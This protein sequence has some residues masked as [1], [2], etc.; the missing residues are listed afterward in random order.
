MPRLIHQLPKAR[1][2]SPSGRARVRINGK[3][4]WLGPYGS[5]EAKEKYNKLI[6]TYLANDRKIPEVASTEVP[7]IKRETT[8]ARPISIQKTVTTLPIKV[9]TITTL[10]ARFTEWADSNYRHPDGTKTRQSENFKHVTKPLREMFGT[11]PVADFDSPRL[12][13]LRES[14]IDKKLAR[15]TIN[16]M[17]SRVRWIFKWG[18]ARGLV[19]NEV[20]S[21]LQA[22]APLQPHR[23][24]RE[25]SGTR[26]SVPWEVVEKTLEYLP[27]LIRSFVLVAFHSGARVGELTKLTTRMIDMTTNPWVVNLIQHKTAHKGKSRCLYFGPN[28]QRA[29]QPFLLANRPDAPIFSPLRVDGR[30]KKRRGKRLPGLVYARS[31]LAQ[32]LRR[33]IKRAGVEHWSLAQLRHSAALRITNKYDLETTRQILGHVTV[34]MTRHYAQ[35]ADRAGKEAVKMIG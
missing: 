21:R 12:I 25:T 1:L 8:E 7:D 10:I 15:R 30:Q 16:Q 20:L 33:A 17:V 35:E 29:L 24:G 13:A 27:P 28:A 32:V 31:S 14:W 4:H 22:L 23:G 26:G 5:P 3:D 19:S 6:A 34:E 2:H 18:I 11:L 9:V